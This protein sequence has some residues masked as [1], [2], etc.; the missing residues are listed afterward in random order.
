MP[1]YVIGSCD[2]SLCICD[3]SLTLQNV[4]IHMVNLFVVCMIIKNVAIW[5][6]YGR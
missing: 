4:N 3:P 6:A 1:I 5:F 2:K